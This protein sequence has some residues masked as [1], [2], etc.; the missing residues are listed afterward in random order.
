MKEAANCSNGPRCTAT[1][2]ARRARRSR[3]CSR[4]A[5]TC[6]ST[7]TGR[8]RGKCASGWATT[9]SAFSSCRRRCG[10]CARGSS[11]GRKTRP[12]DRGR[13]ENARKEIERWRHYHYVVV[14]DDLNRAYRDV[15]TIVTAE[16]LRATRDEAG[17][18]QLVERLMDE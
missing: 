1:A 18:E 7:S 5:A 15:K 9:S 16:R 10:N 4:R 2:T 6:C 11:G 8:A 14:N 13:F 17:V 12:L 3:R